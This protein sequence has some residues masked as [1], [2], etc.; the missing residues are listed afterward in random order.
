MRTYTH[1]HT[2]LLC[3]TDLTYKVCALCPTEQ[4]RPRGWNCVLFIH[5]ILAVSAEEEQGD[6]DFVSQLTG[7][8]TETISS[9]KGHFKGNRSPA[10][11]AG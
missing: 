11:P 4:P 5:F 3:E 2:L 9:G 8:L 6:I 1:R 7:I 10:G